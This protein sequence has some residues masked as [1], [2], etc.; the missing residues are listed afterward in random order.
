MQFKVF[1]NPPPEAPVYDGTVLFL[2]MVAVAAA[3]LTV[4][5]L[6]QRTSR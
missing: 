2:I 4:N 3:I 5:W 6:R 1:L